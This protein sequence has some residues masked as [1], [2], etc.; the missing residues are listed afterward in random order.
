MLIDRQY[1]TLIIPKVYKHTIRPD[2]EKLV[3][4]LTSAETIRFQENMRRSRTRYA[5]SLM[6]QLT[7]I[8][9]LRED[10]DVSASTI[11]QE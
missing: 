6:L 4:V 2:F 5:R 3:N 11:D 10:K 1:D 7:K 9:T 8:A